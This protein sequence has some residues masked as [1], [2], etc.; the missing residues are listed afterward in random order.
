M[1]NPH[2]GNK[3]IVGE[4][5]ENDIYKKS[6]IMYIAE[7]ALEYLISILVTGSYLATLTKHIGISDSLTG[8]IS[9]FISLGCVFQLISLFIR[10]SRMKPFVM[11][12]SI[13]NQLLFM[14]LYVIPVINISSAAKTVIFV[15]LI[16]SAYFIYNIAHPKKINWFMSLVDDGIRGRFTANKEIVSLLSGMI[17]TFLM[18]SLIDRFEAAGNIKSA[19]TVCAAVIFTLTVLHTLT[20][21][22]SKEKEVSEKIIKSD[23]L[24][25]KTAVLRDKNVIRVT[26]VFV[27][28]NI[29]NYSTT[30]FFGTYQI[31]ELG[32]GLTFVSV[33]QIISSLARMIFSRF[34]GSYADRK[35]FAAMIKLCF[36][37][38][39]FGFVFAVFCTP[40]NGRVFFTVYSILQAVAMSGINSA[41]INLVFDN[42]PSEKRADSLAISQALSGIAG[43]IATVSVS[44]LVTHIQKNG[45]RLFGINV[46]AQQVTAFIALV[47]TIISV[48]YVSI[49]I[50]GKRNVKNDS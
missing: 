41:L 47:F 8:I 35:S 3:I 11:I 24:K 37:I 19:F 39:C 18:G 12:F 14:F 15:I 30:P 6:R 16:F 48:I 7:A 22:F 1:T 23:L 42:V 43:F 44:L 21:T 10:R 20:M 40:Q 50:I 5:M 27:L 34:M 28:W 29:A 2:Y 25:E 4:I 49:F 46:Y 31:K 38:M 9:S 13:A 33:L 45:N 36:L 17:F 26:V 32:F